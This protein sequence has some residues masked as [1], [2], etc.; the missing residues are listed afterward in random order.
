G[1]SAP[2]IGLLVAFLALSAVTFLL[3][4]LRHRRWASMANE[5]EDELRRGEMARSIQEGLYRLT[6][7][8]DVRSVILGCYRDMVRLFKDRGVETDDYLTARE[9]ESLAIR[10]LRLSSES[11]RSLRELFEVARYSTHP[12]TEEDRR[13]AADCL[14]RVKTE[15]EA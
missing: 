9:L 1:I 8:D 6:L 14:E 2:S 3:S 11:S 7:G 10:R 5:E 4:T 12:L 15:L 13:H